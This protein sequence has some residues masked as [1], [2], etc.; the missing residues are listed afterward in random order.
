[1]EFNS[2]ETIAQCSNSAAPDATNCSK[3]RRTQESFVSPKLRVVL[4][5]R[6][7]STTLHNFWN[8]AE[9]SQ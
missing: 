7:S 1:M 8:S 6:S 9:M 4:A 3:R 2:S 5:E